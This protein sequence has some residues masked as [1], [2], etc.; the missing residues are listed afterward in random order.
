MEWSSDMSLPF[1]TDLFKSAIDDPLLQ[2]G[3]E[4]ADE[5]ARIVVQLVLLQKESSFRSQC[6]ILQTSPTNALMAGRLAPLRSL[7]E[8]IAS[9]IIFRYGGCE[10]AAF[11][12]F[13]LGVFA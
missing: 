2:S 10:G 3:V 7:M 11:T 4:V 6:G 9:W 8:A 1:V 5:F 12:D 13:I